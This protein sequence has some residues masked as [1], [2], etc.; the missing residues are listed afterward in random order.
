MKLYLA[1]PAITLL[2]ACAT[3]NPPETP[4]DASLRKLEHA[5]RDIQQQWGVTARLSTLKFKDDVPGLDIS[6]IEVDDPLRKVIIFPGGYQGTLS[7]L[8]EEL[9]SVTGYQYFAPAGKRPLE[10]VPV[11][12]GEQYR[13]IAEY[14]YDAGIQAGNRATVVLDVKSKSFQITYTGY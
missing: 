3:K 10:D 14:V 12:F 2:T 4:H 7:K 1:I 8:L 6:K 11:V 9:A 13:T 5:T